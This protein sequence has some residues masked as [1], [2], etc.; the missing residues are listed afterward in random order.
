VRVHPLRTGEVRLPPRALDRPTGPL[1]DLRGLG[2][3]RRKAR[4]SWVPVPVFLVEHPGAGAIL[5]DT[6]FHESV[7]DDPRASLGRRQPKVLPV[8]MP[9][10]ESAPAQLRARGIEPEDVRVVVLTHL[11][12]DH[13]SGVAQFP[14]ATFVVSAA[15]WAAA[16]RR[17][18][19]DG[20]RHAQFDHPFDWR[21]V[22]FGA[23]EVDA[24]ETFGRAVDLFGDGAVRLLF[25]PGH[26]DG[27]QSVLLRLSGGELLLTGDAAYARRTID[28]DLVPVFRS[29]THRYRRS[30]G[31]IRRYLETHPDTRVVCGHDAAAWPAL[32][33]VF[34]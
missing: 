9:A 28:E 23:D 14:A 7:A 6:G 16:G 33:A 5:V 25:T 17:G 12:N 21:L 29:D 10:G 4:W 11:H 27:H 32:P 1:G 22:D 19:R 15:E 26:S 13:A 30:L 31:E 24:Y 3:H 8:R 34:T 20:Y 2:L 18:F